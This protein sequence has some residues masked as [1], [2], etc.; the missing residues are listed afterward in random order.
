MSDSVSIRSLSVRAASVAVALAALFAGPAGAQGTTYTACYVPS[1]GAVYLIKRS[2]LPSACL[3]TA[4]VE[5][6]W[7]EGGAVA[8]GSVTTAKIV[9][10]AVTTA[11]IA[12]G[13]SVDLLQGQAPSAFAPVGHNHD[14][15]Y[16]TRPELSD[17]G[18]INSVSNAVTWTR[19]K[20]VPAGF[21]DGVD[22]VGTTTFTASSPISIAGNDIRLS[23]NGCVAGEVWKWTGALWDCVPDNNSGGTV[24]SV[25]AGT[26]LTGGTITT[27]GTVSVAFAGPGAA[28][29]VARSDHTHAT[30]FGNTAVGTGALVAS[31]SGTANTAVGLFALTHNTA[32]YGNTALGDGALGANTTGLQNTA[33]GVTALGASSTSDGNTA[34]GIYALRF[35]TGNFNIAFGASAGAGVTTGS[36]N[37]HIGNGG[38]STDDHTIRV[39]VQGTHTATFIAGISGAT[40]SG[41]SAVFVNSAGQLGTLTSSA[42][43]KEAV[44]PLGE[45]SRG[46]LRLRPVQFR[47]KPEYDDGSRLIQ[48]GLIAE[49]VAQVFPE[50][51]LYGPS[52]EVETVRYHLLAP[53]ILN[54]LQRQERELAALRQVVDELRAELR[55]RP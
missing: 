26:G 25:T 35:S 31:T 24:T 46:L 6:S 8:D 1:V 38:L 14:T 41:G 4:H 55:R 28:T 45:T 5:F 52:G 50:L 15:A 22:D 17:A 32:G 20:G 2:G 3:S 33:V 53:L 47:Y 36:S 18:T 27:S 34:I 51:V 11:K 21:A 40:T 44:A 13:T 54:E 12:A 39:G 7:T 16:P 37:I 9:D 43:F 10:G 49:E 42:R 23:T 48:Y 29:T 19:L 30:L